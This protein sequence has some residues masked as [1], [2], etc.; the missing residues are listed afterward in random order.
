LKNVFFSPS[1]S[2]KEKEKNS[3]TSALEERLQK[4]VQ[5][6]AD[7]VVVQIPKAHA[8]EQARRHRV[9]G[10]REPQAQRAPQILRRHRAPHRVV[11]SRQRG[12]RRRV[13]FEDDGRGVHASVRVVRGRRGRVDERDVERRDVRV[14]VHAGDH[15]ARRREPQACGALD[16]GARSVV[17]VRRLSRGL[18]RDAPGVE[19]PG[20]VEKRRR[21]GGG[22]GAGGAAPKLGDE[23]GRL[24]RGAALARLHRQ[25]HQVSRRRPRV[26]REPPQGRPQHVQGFL[27][28]GDDEGVD[29]AADV[30]GD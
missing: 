3:L 16:G 7:R 13:A 23:L 29:E 19:R 9:V 28:V 11:H 1:L 21:G 24:G 27:V 2:Q 18:A 25:R 15:D 4:H 6:L 20:E 12:H 30:D 5:V 14:G 26:R 8:S 22:R 17:G 10:Y